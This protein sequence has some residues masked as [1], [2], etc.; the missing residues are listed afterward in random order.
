MVIVVVH[1]LKAIV[2]SPDSECDQVI[3][4]YRGRFRVVYLRLNKMP[5]TMHIINLKSATMGSNWYKFNSLVVTSYYI[6]GV[7]T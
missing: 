4:L 1:V 3:L 7:G 5:K 6:H 2:P